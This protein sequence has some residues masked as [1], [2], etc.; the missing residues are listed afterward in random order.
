MQYILTV[1]DS[2]IPRDISDKPIP[3]AQNEIILDL[4]EGEDKGRLFK[5]PKF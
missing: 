5:M 1:I 3:F 2:D 4:F